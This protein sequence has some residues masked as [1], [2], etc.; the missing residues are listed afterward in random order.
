MPPPALRCPGC[1]SSNIIDDDL[2]C[3]T[4]LV[5]VDCG[6]VVSEGTLVNDVVGGAGRDRD[7]DTS[8]ILHLH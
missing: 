7:E 1:G 8:T 6:A 5:C 3:Q 2:H 4:Q